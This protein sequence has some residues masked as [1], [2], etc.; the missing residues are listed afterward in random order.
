MKQQ[1]RQINRKKSHCQLLN[2]LKHWCLLLAGIV[3][4]NAVPGCSGDLDHLNDPDDAGPAGRSEGVAAPSFPETTEELNARFP[5]MQKFRIFALGGSNRGFGMLAHYETQPNEIYLRRQT[6]PAKNEPYTPICTLSVFDPDGNCVVDAE[7]TDQENEDG[8]YV[9]EVPAAKSGKGIWRVSLSGGRNGDWFELGLPKTEIWGVRG[10]MAF[11]A[12]ETLPENIFLY[13]PETVK[14]IYAEKWGGGKALTLRSPDGNLLGQAAQEE[15]KNRHLLVMN[16]PDSDLI[17][18]DRSDCLD[19]AIAFDGIPGLLCPT[20]DAARVLKGGTVEADGLLLA[21]PLQARIRKQMLKLVSQG[22]D[23]NLTFAE[24]IPDDLQNPRL[25]AL[26]FGKYSPLSGLKDALANQVIDPSSPYLGAVKVKPDAIDW[27][28]FL[29]ESCT[30]PFDSECLTNAVSVK[31]RLNAA[32]GNP[33]LVR[34][35]ALAAFFHFVSMQGDDT[36]REGYFKN[37]SYPMT[38]AFFIYPALAQALHNLTPFLDDETRTLW[39]QALAAVGTK[40]ADFQAYESNQWAH[41]IMAHLTTYLTTG[42]P[43]FLGIFE[44]EMTA[45]V[46]NTYGPASKFGQHPAGFYLEEYGPD[47]NYDHLNF[48]CVCVCYYFY[49]DMKNANPE[50]VA[51]LKTSIEKNLEFKKFFWLPQADGDAFGPNAFNCR[52]ASNLAGASWPGDYIASPEFDL[53][54]R[55]FQMRPLPDHGAGSAATFSHMANTDEWAMRVI[56]TYLPKKDEAFKLGSASGGW[57][58]ELFKAYSMPVT[59]KPAKLPFEAEGGVWQLPGLMA[60]K[61]GKI[62]TVLFH[63]VI[64]ANKNMRGN[65]HFGGGMDAV[66]TASTGSAV[67]A[68]IPDSKHVE[69]PED[70]ICTA[71]FGKDKDGKFFCS[72]RERSELAWTEPDKKFSVTE[73]VRETNA[74]LRW[75]YTILD[76]AFTVDVSYQSDATADAMLN[77]P[78]MMWEGRTITLDEAG[79]TATVATD[80]GEVTITIDSAGAASLTEPLKASCGKQIRSLRI[81]VAAD[82]NPLTFT[83]TAK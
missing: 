14:T 73:T 46:D 3:I 13:V 68:M 71:V 17:L 69:K 72:G 54:Q 1:T 78:L 33:A 43:R 41:M 76:N 74:T 30:S 35:A 31:T 82:G 65:G 44:R 27:Q 38:H 25:E 19:D 16:K 66:W 11:G 22:L 42:N 28:T 36:I 50:L 34:R 40:I 20:P 63:D 7:I 77:I 62:Y 79:K 39:Q 29:H 45:Y 5:I 52:T 4:L 56:E 6:N 55:R 59:A 60:F 80:T 23:V 18:V 51:K 75:D 47:G 37:N 53:A 49:R 2:R 24:K 57:T 12:G 83:I 26:M 21:G 8:E 32:Y 10:E 70:V 67:N 9:L 81:S 58:A 15:G 48:Y 61:T 64:G